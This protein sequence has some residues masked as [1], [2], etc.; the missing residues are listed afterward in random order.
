[1]IESQGL[2]CPLVD[3]GEEPVYILDP[4]GKCLNFLWMCDD[5]DPDP[6]KTKDCDPGFLVHP[7]LKVCKPRDEVPNC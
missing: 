5:M 2:E 6:Q 1:M 7:E 4:N 3:S